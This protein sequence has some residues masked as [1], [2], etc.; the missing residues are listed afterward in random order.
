M[1]IITRI[2]WPL[3]IDQRERAGVR[4]EMIYWGFWL[5]SVSYSQASQ[6]LHWFLNLLVSL[7]SRFAQL[8]LRRADKSHTNCDCPQVYVV[9]FYLSTSWCVWPMTGLS[10]SKDSPHSHNT[11]CYLRK[12]STD[13][14]TN[15]QLLLLSLFR[16]SLR[17]RFIK[18]IFTGK[19]CPGPLLLAWSQDCFESVEIVLIL[20]SL[21]SWKQS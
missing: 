17:S 1:A 20:L 15:S 5:W 18:I 11:K 3:Q 13:S 16:P 2:C 6:V 19:S 4:L 12:W 8:I 21:K 7:A 14:V 10:G 9:N